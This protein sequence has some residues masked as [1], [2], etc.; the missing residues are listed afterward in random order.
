MSAGGARMTL[1]VLSAAVL[2]LGVGA[3][4]GEDEPDSPAATS[5]PAGENLGAIKDYLLEHSDALATSTAKLAEQGKSYNELAASTDFDYNELLDSKRDEVRSSIEEMQATYIKANPQY[6][7]MEGVVA[8][9]PEL[10]EFDVIIDAGSDASEPESAVPFDVKVPGGKTLK[11]PGNFFFLT[12]TSLYGTNPAFQAKGAKADL[13]GDG[14]VTFPEA[15]PDANV[16]LA[17]TRDF[18]TQAQALDKAAKAWTPERADALQALVT[19]T[20][21]M[22]EYFGQWKI[23]RFVAGNKA[24]EQAFAAASRLQDIEDILGGLVLVYE[25]V[26][27]A[28]AKADAAQAEQTGRDLKALHAF[29]V[30]LHKREQDGTRFTAEQADTLGGE[31]QGRAEAIAGQVSQAAAQLGIKLES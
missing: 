16:V 1:A 19:M 28:I 26:E 11:Q 18:A 15:L 5:T 7:E 8:G 3:C 17:F 10:A 23:S 25:S 22:S 6:E 14:K 9:V 12:E 31:A 30:D 24:D 4:G 21:T 27:P 20:P 2:A 29:A 13:D